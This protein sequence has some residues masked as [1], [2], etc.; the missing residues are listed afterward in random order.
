M[1]NLLIIVLILSTLGVIF[2]NQVADF[3][4][5]YI[6]TE[7][8]LKRI[9]GFLSGKE[10]RKEAQEIDFVL[11]APVSELNERFQNIC[12]K[13][14]KRYQKKIQSPSYM[15]LLPIAVQNFFEK[16]DYLVINKH[17]ILDI[18]KVQVKNYSGQEYILIGRD[19]EDDADYLVIPQQNENR[20]F[21]SYHPGSEMFLEEAARITDQPFISKDY[22]ASFENFLCYMDIYHSK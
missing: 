6:F 4:L 14:G 5:K 11:N 19:R 20:V 10:L 13:Y 7:K 15:Q 16:Y 8:R 22:F 1:L 9:D 12:K 21:I 18:K 3:L 2:Q 17:K